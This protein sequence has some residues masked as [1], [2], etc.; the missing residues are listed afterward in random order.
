MKNKPVPVSYERLAA[1]VK[2]AYI[3]NASIPDLKMLARGIRR[4]RI[5]IGRGNS[6]T[7][8]SGKYKITTRAKRH[9]FF[10]TWLVAPKAKVTV[11]VAGSSN[12]YQLD[13]P[14]HWKKFHKLV[15]ADIAAE[16]RKRNGR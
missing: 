10:I 5:V 11:E 9:F 12:R 7:S 2:A 13:K 4:P 3:N 8:P 15:E 1:F 6:V 16:M 14:R